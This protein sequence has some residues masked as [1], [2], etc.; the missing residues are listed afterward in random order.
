M[1]WVSL[2][3][4]RM[5]ILSKTKQLQ[6]NFG[7]ILHIKPLSTCRALATSVLDIHINALLAKHMTASKQNTLLLAS[8][9]YRTVDLA[10][11]IRHLP[12]QLLNCKR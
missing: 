3:D 4:K 10:I 2:L 8:I 9:A 5:Q 12:L 11:K 7:H 1:K 6:P